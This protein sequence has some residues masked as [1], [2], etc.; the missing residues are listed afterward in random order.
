MMKN[1]LSCIYSSNSKLRTSAYTEKK[2]DHIYLSAIQ[3][4]VNVKYSAYSERIEMAF[5][6][7]DT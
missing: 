6:I 2:T 1:K 4:F 7:R 3:P 5:Y